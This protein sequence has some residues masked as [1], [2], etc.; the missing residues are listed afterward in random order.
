MVN[1]TIK[2]TLKNV[3]LILETAV[4]F[5]FLLGNAQIVYAMKI[6]PDIPF[7]FTQ[8]RSRFEKVHGVVYQ[9]M[10]SQ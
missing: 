3:F 1:V 6:K 4:N 5:K 10:K 8:M 7:G 2:I 9:L